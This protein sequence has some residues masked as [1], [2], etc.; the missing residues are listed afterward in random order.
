MNA[1]HTSHHLPIPVMR[2]AQ[3]SYTTPVGIPLLHAVSADFYPGEWV[4]VVGR[5]GSGKSTLAK[6]LQGLLQPTSGTVQLNSAQGRG[7]ILPNPDHQ[8]IGLTVEDDIFFGLEQL[9]LPLAVMEERIEEALQL[10]GL[11]TKR[12]VSPQQ[13][14]GGEKQRLA[15]ASVL[16][17]KPAVI[18]MDDAASMLDAASRQQLQ[19]LMSDLQEHGH[20]VIQLTHNLDEALSADRVL[21]LHEGELIDLGA[22][23]SL[24]QHTSLLHQA[25]IRPP[26]MLRLHVELVDEAVCPELRSTL[27]IDE[28]AEQ[29][30]TFITSK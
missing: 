23:M 3:V 5:N 1:S 28:M 6:L 10:M 30:C 29:L 4:A 21:I 7:L 13:L 22:P 19:R 18:I 24:A 25:G 26:F 2:L 12:Q 11:Q 27:H 16:A 9:E 14:S 20:T 17:M 8:Y 15:I